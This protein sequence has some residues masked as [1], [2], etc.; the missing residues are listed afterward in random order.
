M[1]KFSSKNGLETV[2]SPVPL[3]P[4]ARWAASSRQGRANRKSI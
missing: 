2:D 3:V 1:K 4:L